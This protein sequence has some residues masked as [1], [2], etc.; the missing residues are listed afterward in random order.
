MK[1][2]FNPYLPLNEY[3]PDGEPHVFGDRVYIYGSHD[4]EGGDFFCMLDYVTYSAPVDDLKNWRYEGVIYKASQDPLYK[5][6]RYMYAP[7]VVRGNDGRYYLYYSMADSYPGCSFIMSVAVCDTPNG[8]FEYLG[9]VRHKDGTPL[10][11]YLIFDPGLINDNGHIRLYYGIWYDF[12]ENPNYTREQSIVKQMEMYQKSREEIENTP[13][14]VQGPVHVELEN[15]MMTV[16][17]GPRRIFPVFYKGTSFEHHEFFEASSMR[18]LGDKYYFIYSSFQNHE[19]CYAVSDYPD[20][21]YRFGG[22]IISNGD[23]GYKGRKPEN[24]LMRSGNNHGSIENINGKWYIFYHRHTLKTE[25]SRQGCAE[26][27]EILPDG[28]IPQVEMTSCGLNGGP[29][30]AKGKYSTAICCN[31]TDGKVPHCA[32]PNARLP[33][34]T[35]RGDDH[36]ITEIENNTMI[37]YKY[38]SFDNVTRI[39]VVYKTYDIKPWGNIVIKLSSDGEPIGTIPITDRA[40]WTRAEAKVSAINGTYPLYFFYEGDGSIE[41]LEFDFE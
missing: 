35:F 5:T 30:L 22:V 17:D 31:L 27:I 7:D 6:Y 3:I 28:F 25:F 14:G 1:Q 41:L 18:K 4:K 26:E 33:H 21:D 24:R 40:E 29:L 37:G 34:L 10:Q 39:G 36:F 32:C 13:G 19:L 9:Y 20:R 8:R 11:D 12:D 2:V 16:K 38:F 23:V 15:D